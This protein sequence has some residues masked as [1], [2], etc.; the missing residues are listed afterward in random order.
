MIM[1]QNRLGHFAVAVRARAFLRVVFMNGESCRVDSQFDEL[2]GTDMPFD[3]V[4]R[5]MEV[6]GIL[7]VHHAPVHQF[8]V[9]GEPLGFELLCELTH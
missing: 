7:G 1:T 8:V 5:N 9:I 3:D 4:G 6:L 2:A